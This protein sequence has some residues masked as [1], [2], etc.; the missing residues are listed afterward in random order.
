MNHSGNKSLI[1]ALNTIHTIKIINL[2][3]TDHKA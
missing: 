1:L 3:A 2:E